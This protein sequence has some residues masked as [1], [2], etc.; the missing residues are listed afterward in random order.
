M[1]PGQLWHPPSCGTCGAPDW[2]W[3]LDSGP[4]GK[5]TGRLVWG[6]LQCFRDRRARGVA[7]AVVEGQRVV[8]FHQLR[9]GLQVAGARAEVGWSTQARGRFAR[10]MEVF[11]PDV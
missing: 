7:A 10:K 5:P 6:T 8:G 1:E 2:N 3:H 11:S 9:C 4:L